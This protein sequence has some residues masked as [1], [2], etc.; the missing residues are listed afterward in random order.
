MRRATSIR[1]CS[2]ARRLF[3]EADI[4]PLEEAPHRATAARDPS[5]T[6]RRDDLIQRQIRVVGNQ[7][8]QKVGVRLQRREA[9]TA[10]LGRDAWF[11][12][13]AASI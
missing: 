9:T 8:Q 4:V 6:H 7:R 13:A 10:R 3:F 2:A 1:S 5:L 11:H 12:A